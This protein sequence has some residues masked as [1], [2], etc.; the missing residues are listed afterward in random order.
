MKTLA[1]I[2]AS[3]SISLVPA[4]ALSEEQASE[5]VSTT[6]EASSKDVVSTIV[7]MRKDATPY[8]A[9]VNVFIDGEKIALVHDDEYVE[10]PVS[11]GNHTLETRFPFFPLMLPPDKKS[12]SLA[13][14][15]GERIYVSLGN[16]PYKDLVKKGVAI[17][18]VTA[19]ATGGQGFAVYQ[20]QNTLAIQPAE[21]A[22]VL[23]MS[24][25]PLVQS[26]DHGAPNNS[27]KGDGS[28]E[29]RP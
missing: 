19:V 3:L 28:D 29:P 21:V 12:I 4:Y 11:P 23:K 5:Q 1:Y 16:Q 15:P 6:S 10:I 8:A 9:G 24:L 13:A 22:E 27:L 18:L 2:F 7:F 17:G 20:G 25:Q 26:S 14:R